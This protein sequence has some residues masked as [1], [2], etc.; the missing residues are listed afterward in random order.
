M[1]IKP[2]LSGQLIEGKKCEYSSNYGFTRE[3]EWNS[4]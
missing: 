4:I 3:L 1:F 2:I